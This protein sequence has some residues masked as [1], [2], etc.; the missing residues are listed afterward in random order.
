MPLSLLQAALLTLRETLSAVK[1]DTAAIRT[2]IVTAANP[3]Q[4]RSAQQSA[5]LRHALEEDLRLLV[6]GTDTMQLMLRMGQYYTALYAGRD[7]RAALLWRQ[8][9]TLEQRLE[10]YYM[11]LTFSTDCLDLISNDALTR[12]QLR[13]VIA[14]CRKIRIDQHWEDAVC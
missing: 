5:Q 2:D 1:H 12:T 4:Q 6:Y 10:Q 8:I 3:A 7:D 13:E 9:D 14:R 11:P